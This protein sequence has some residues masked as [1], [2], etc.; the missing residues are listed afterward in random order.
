MYTDGSKESGL[1]GYIKRAGAETMWKMIVIE[2][3]TT[4]AME[5][6]DTKEGGRRGYT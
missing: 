4:E 2:R 6:G 5:T 1:N 3:A